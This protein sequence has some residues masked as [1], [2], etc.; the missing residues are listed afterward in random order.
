ML[1]HFFLRL[2]LPELV[3]RHG[4]DIHDSNVLPPRSNI[5]KLR[6]LVRH[7]ARDTRGFR[8]IRLFPSVQ[9]AAEDSFVWGEL[10]DSDSSD[11]DFEGSV[12]DVPSAQVA[13]SEDSSSAFDSQEFI[14]TSGSSSVFEGFSD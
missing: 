10:E 14:S 13:D 11:D 12:F 6:S 7:S 4:D 5:K 9:S 8:G 2:E 1:T 3:S